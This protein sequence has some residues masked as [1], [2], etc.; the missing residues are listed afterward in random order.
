MGKGL[1]K[2][3]KKWIERTVSNDRSYKIVLY[4][5]LFLFLLSVVLQLTAYALLIWSFAYDS[6]IGFALQITAGVL[7]IIFVVY[8]LNASDNP[9]MRMNWI[10][11]ILIAP[12][13]GV[14]MYLFNG[15]GAPTRKLR[16][17]LQNAKLEICQA[18]QSQGVQ[19]SAP[20]DGSMAVVEKLGGFPV[21]TDG[22]VH[23][24]PSGEDAFVDML[25]E[26]NKA[27]KY[28]LMEYF[29]IAHG[30][31]WGEILKIVLEKAMQGVQVRI[32]YDDFGCMVTLPP[33][34]EKYL[35]SLHENIKC[36]TFNDVVPVF[37]VRMNN[38][39]H[40]KMLIIDGKTAFT[41]GINLADEYI[42]EKK[43]F[44]YWKD[45]AVQVTGSAVRSFVTAFF[46][47]WNA[48]YKEREDVVAYLPPVKEQDERIKTRIQPYD[49]SPLDSVPIAET[50]YAVMI[51]E[52]KNYVWICTPYLVLDDKMRE[53]LC[54]ASL[55]GVDVRIVTPSIPDKKTTY[56]LTRANYDV[57]LRSG[58]R[59][60][61]YTPGF[62]HA[63]SIL[64]DDCRAI[65][66]TVN[67]DYRSF[68]HHFENAVAFS[69]CDAVIHLKKDCE[70]TFAQSKE[71]TKENYKKSP[72]G[73]VFDAVLRA[74][75]TLF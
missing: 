42:N 41:G 68:Y 72:F 44:G 74:F 8:L 59:I 3:R 16:R 19:T 38:R 31:M 61:E 14:P 22:E 73:R 62:I 54:L 24:Y 67:F 1:S 18:V 10:V 52:A 63:K 26:L 29:I 53:T 56:R 13:F 34:Y 9:S 65:V 36:V 45:S 37:A 11:V 25:A 47:V 35:E 69:M 70:N 7:A 27:E 75:E 33:D 58:V 57:L 49:D 64:C 4:N 12:V 20:A 43:R 40:R 32:V 30:K 6:A 60:Y 28:I 71:I 46:T 66:G 15:R 51:R 23:Y 39:D 50:A 5:R 21:Y 2:R 17:K 48:V 55:R